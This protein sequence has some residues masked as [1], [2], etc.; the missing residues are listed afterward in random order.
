MNNRN[1][2]SI[3]TEPKKIS[4]YIKI[5]KNSRLQTGVWED[6]EKLCFQVKTSMKVG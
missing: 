6:A 4:K 2:D 5:V 1:V 3:F